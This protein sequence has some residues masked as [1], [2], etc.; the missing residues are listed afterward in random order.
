MIGSGRVFKFAVKPP[1]T[2]EL[3]GKIIDLMFWPAENPGRSFG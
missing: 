3:H 2:D 1:L